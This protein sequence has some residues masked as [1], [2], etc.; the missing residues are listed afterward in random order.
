MREG[1]FTVTAELTLDRSS[2]ADDVR[3]QADLL[4]RYVDAVQVSDNPYAWVQMSA[5]AAAAILLDHG[6]DAVPIV[7]CRDRNRDALRAELVGLQAIGV[8]SLF[9][10]RGHGVPS[11]HALPARAVF[12]T[13]GQELI[14]M[15][16]AIGQ[17]QPRDEAFFIGTGARV[18][19]ANRGWRAES[20]VKRYDAGARFLQ[21]QLCYNLEMLRHYMARFVE[22]G[23]DNR[24]RLVV[25]LSPLPS[26]VTARW[27]KENLSDS[28]VPAKVIK[29]L[30]QADN[31]A[32]E[33][34]A[35]CAELMREIASI[36]GVS[37]IHLMTTGDPSAILS[38]LEASGLR[39]PI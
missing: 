31:P 7:G 12:D 8:S 9:L 18:F 4:G 16:A 6:I 34:I 1:R 26:V 25:S 38:T 2:T 23:F 21:T 33:G 36:E 37:G 27:I 14:A 20:L 32:E 15:A 3:R 28:R 13:T 5:L 24:Y 29:R 10:M 22:A 30:E 39:N 35:L 17:R 19:R 11:D